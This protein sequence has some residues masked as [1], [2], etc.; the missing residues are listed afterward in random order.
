MSKFSKALMWDPRGHRVAIDSPLRHL[1]V[2][3]ETIRTAVGYRMRLAATFEARAVVDS[4]D[5]GAVA[6]VGRNLRRAISE[7]VFGEFRRDLL[8]AL[9]QLSD[10]DYGAAQASIHRVLQEMFDD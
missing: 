2:E 7:E 1:S 10:R 9:E 5:D 6:S 8:M 3:S 4:E